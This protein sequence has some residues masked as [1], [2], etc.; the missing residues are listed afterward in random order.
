MRLKWHAKWRN[1]V[2]KGVRSGLPARSS[3][4]TPQ[5]DA[6]SM[7][8]DFGPGLPVRFRPSTDTQNGPIAVSWQCVVKI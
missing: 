3:T 4:L 7:S 1:P 6:I 5:G 2:R 8:F